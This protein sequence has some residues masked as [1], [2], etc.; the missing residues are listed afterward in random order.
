LGALDVVDAASY[1]TPFGIYRVAA[2]LTTD[3]RFRG[4][5]LGLGS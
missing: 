4:G 3:R 5:R 1:G 2:S